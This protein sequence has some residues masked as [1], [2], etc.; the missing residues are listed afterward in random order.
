MIALFV[1]DNKGG[2]KDVLFRTASPLL[3]KDKKSVGSG[4]K[5]SMTSIN[6]ALV[7]DPEFKSKA[8]ELLA[9][10][11]LLPLPSISG[12]LL[13]GDVSACVHLPTL[14]KVYVS[15][16]RPPEWVAFYSAAITALQLSIEV[17]VYEE[18]LVARGAEQQS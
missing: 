17:D 5:A 15:D 14:R 3:E 16:G 8:W 9:F 2:I 4:T 18:G 13:Y 11:A 10:P 6:N 1:Q 12:E 7:N